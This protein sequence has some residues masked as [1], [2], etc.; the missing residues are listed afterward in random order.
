MTLTTDAN[1]RNHGTGSGRLVLPVSRK[2]SCS[3]VVSS[4]SVDSGFDQNQSELGVLVLSV[5]LQVLTDLNGLL[6]KHVKVLGNFGGKSVG[7][8]DT[9]N[10]LSGDRLDLGDTI[11][12]TQDNTNLGR[13]Q[14]LLGELADVFL[15]ISRG[16]L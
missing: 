12:I 2:L 11:G 14:S 16:D 9:N 5:A 15:D 3:S 8:E 13:G 4:K 7:L 6:D 1:L 10:L